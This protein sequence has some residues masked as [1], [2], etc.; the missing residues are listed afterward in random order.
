LDEQSN[1]ITPQKLSGD[2]V[3]AFVLASSAGAPLRLLLVGPKQDF[4]L[5]SA[6]YVA[7]GTY[8]VI[9]DTLA[10]ATDGKSIDTEA[11]MSA[12]RNSKPE[13]IVIVGGVDKKGREPI[14]AIARTLALAYATEEESA[15]PRV[16]FAG[17]AELR[18]QVAE[19][20]NPVFELRAVEDIR[21]TPDSES[22]AAALLELENMY[23]ERRMGRVP[24]FGAL[25]AWSPLP[26]VPAAKAFA[27][28]IRYLAE[29]HKRNVIGVDLGGMAVTVASVLDKRFSL[30]IRGDLGVGYSIGGVLKQTSVED[31]LRWVPSEVE[32]EVGQAHNTLL[33]KELHPAT[34]PQS[35]QELLLEQSLAKEAMRLAWRDVQERWAMLGLSPGTGAQ[36]E[37]DLIVGAG[38]LLTH[39][40]TPGQAALML[41][42]VIQPTGLSDIVIDVANLTV[43]LGAVAT[44]QPLA[45][46]QVIHQDAFLDLGT[47][48][49]P[50]GMAGEGEIA[51]NVRITYQDGRALEVEVPFGS[52]EVIPLPVAGEARLE[53]RPTRYFDI[54]QGPGKAAETDVTGGAAG[55]L[56][57]ARGRPLPLPGDLQACRAKV[58]EWMWN[59]G[60]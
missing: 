50:V 6:R 33:N 55:V 37:R 31:I 20:L 28:V 40:S 19:I 26:A 34:V 22:S 23:Q 48:V 25:S 12:L 8:T 16:L 58:Q 11:Q 44:M 9:A 2:G 10:L 45:A 46:A 43:P 47:V 39:T 18:P 57:D 54:G 30:V 29:S 38:H 60:A 24:G 32:L 59:I 36:R 35:H 41:L 53:L 27:Y 21:P 7:A 49:A 42:D 15:K 51:I 4:G 17:H 52:L 56:I 14:L 5:S 1:L 3:D 13:M